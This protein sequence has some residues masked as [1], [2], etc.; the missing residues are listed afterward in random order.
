MAEEKIVFKF[1]A[2][3]G[4]MR[5]M[6]LGISGFFMLG[7]GDVGVA[8]RIV[9]VE[10]AARGYGFY[11]AIDDAQTRAEDECN[12]AVTAVSSCRTLYVGSCLEGECDW[13]VLCSFACTP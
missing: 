7:I 10:G 2:T 8:N 13:R 11:N 4:H 5:L 9:T 1:E 6:F 12:S 3:G